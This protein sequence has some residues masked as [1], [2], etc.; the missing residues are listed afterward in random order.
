MTQDTDSIGIS[1]QHRFST[2]IDGV[3]RGAARS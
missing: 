2:G 3:G 1:Q